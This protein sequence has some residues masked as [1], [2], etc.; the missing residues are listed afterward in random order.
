MNGW[1]VSASV[2]AQVE[3]DVGAGVAR[4]IEHQFKPGARTHR[5]LIV[6]GFERLARLAVDGH[7]ADLRAAHCDRRQARCRGAA[8]TQPDASARSGFELQRRG[9]A[10]GENDIASAPASPAEGRVSKIVLDLA[11][12]VDVPLGQH[13][14]CVEVGIRRLR[15]VH[16]N[17]AEQA[18]P[19]LGGV[20]RAGVGQIEIEAGIRGKR[21]ISA[22]APGL[23]LSWVRPPIPA[24]AFAAR[25]PGKL[26]V[27]GSM[28]LLVNFSLSSS[29]WR[30]RISGPGIAPA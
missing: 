11:A 4:H 1:S 27:V 3:T 12:R 24:A 20:G 15:L 23:S 21:R 7:D 13:H 6:E 17:R 14:C 5:K 22:L 28:S 2:A 29:P 10:I 18:P 26:S 19:L 8:K 9:R 16:D 25:K 30:S